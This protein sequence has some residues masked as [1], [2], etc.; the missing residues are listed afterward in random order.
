MYAKMCELKRKMLRMITSIL[1]FMKKKSLIDIDEIEQYFDCNTHEFFQ[2][3]QRVDDIDDNADD[4]GDDDDDDDDD[5]DDADDDDDEDAT[6]SGSRIRD[7]RL[8]GSHVCT[9]NPDSRRYF[10]QLAS[11]RTTIAEQKLFQLGTHRLLLWLLAKYTSL[12][13]ILYERRYIRNFSGQ[14]APPDRLLTR[15]CFAPRPVCIQYFP[16]VLATLKK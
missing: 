6:I 14:I 16:R 8:N 12:S 7:G 15:S 3:L 13:A 10:D 1:L 11:T 4:D 2:D 5:A 9:C